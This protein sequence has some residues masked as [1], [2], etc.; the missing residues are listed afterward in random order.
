MTKGLNQAIAW[1]QVMHIGMNGNLKSFPYHTKTFKINYDFAAPLTMEVRT[2]ITVLFRTFYY[3]STESFWNHEKIGT[4][5][6]SDIFIKDSVIEY[7]FYVLRWE[8]SVCIKKCYANRVRYS[9]SM[10]KLL[11]DQYFIRRRL[12]YQVDS[13]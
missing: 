7:Y 13:I 1:R 9:K 10:R 2:L 4:S 3:S 6:K 11:P 5:K 12:L 8:L